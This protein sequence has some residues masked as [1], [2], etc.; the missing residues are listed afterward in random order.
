MHMPSANTMPQTEIKIRDTKSY[1]FIF[2]IHLSI[3]FYHFYDGP[4]KQ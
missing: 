1:F 4:G 3:V 2:L